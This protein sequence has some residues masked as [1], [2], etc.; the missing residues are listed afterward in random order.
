MEHLSRNTF[1]SRTAK[2]GEGRIRPGRLL[3]LFVVTCLLCGMASPSAFGVPLSEVAEKRD[4]LQEISGQVDQTKKQLLTVRKKEKGVLGELEATE[5][6]LERTKARLSSLEKQIRSVE[7]GIKEA[8]EDLV[9]SE[10]ELVSAERRLEERLDILR[11]RFRTMYMWGPGDY[12]EALFTASN[13]ADFIGRYDYLRILV[14]NDADC[15]N[16][17][18]LEIQALADQ[19]DEVEK[20]KVSLENKRGQLASMKVD[21]TGEEKQLCLQVQERETQLATLQRERARYEKALDELE[22]TSRELERAIREQQTRDV[23]DGKGIPRWTGKFIKPVNGRISSEFGNRY[24]PILKKN[25]FHSGIDIAVPTGT[26]VRAAADGV[27]IHSG[28]ISGYGYTVIMDHGGGLST[29]YA[30][31]SSLVA[32]A[33]QAVLQGDTIA[34]AGSTGLSTGPHVHFEVRDQGAPVSPWQWLK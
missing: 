26:P 16:E 20:K 6:K 4:Q 27:I 17:V 7:K 1:E 31:N 22:E 23:R 3:I 10:R 2:A 25:R 29:L 18:E 34:R 12:L 14:K 5:M 8:E 33:G 32:K 28:W 11:N 24:H 30:H 19:I 15:L 9:I 13:F 21:F